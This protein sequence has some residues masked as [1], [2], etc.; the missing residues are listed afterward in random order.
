MSMPTI[1]QIVCRFLFNSDTPPELVDESLIRPELAEGDPVWVDALE[2]MSTGGGRF[3]DVARFNYIRRFLEGDDYK[4]LPPPNNGEYYTTAEL[5]SN[6]GI[7]DGLLSIPQYYND[8]FSADFAVRAYVFGSSAFKI[9][10]DARFYVVHNADGTTTRW[11]D[12]VRVEPVTDNFDYDSKDI[13]A[14]ITNYLTKD[15]IDPSGIGRTVPIKFDNCGSIPTQTLQQSD[16]LYLQVRNIAAQAAED[17]NIALIAGLPPYFAGLFVGVMFN[18]VANNI[19]TYESDG[20]FVIYDGKGPGNN[21]V[22]DA[23][24]LSSAITNGLK[25]TIV[26]GG[27]GDDVII[28]T[29]YD[30]ALIGGQGADHLEG[31]KGYDTYF[32][33]DQDTIM[34]S[35]GSGSVTLNGVKLDGE[36][37]QIGENEFRDDKGNIFVYD[38]ASKLLIVN[39]GLRIEN[40]TNGQ[41]GI[42]LKEEPDP[43]DSDPMKPIKDKCQQAAANSSPIILDL[44]GD[45][46]ETTSLSAKTHFDHAADGFAEQTGWVG[47][48]DGFLVRDLNGNGLIDSGRELFGSETLLANG[49]KA[50]NGFEALKELDSNSDGVIDANDAAFAELRIWKDA[51]GNGK[52]DE[53]E[54][55]TLAEAGVQ[56]I[57]LAYTQANQTDAQ[58]NAH[59]QIGSYTTTDGQIRA[60]TDVWFATDP[61]YSVATERGAVSRG[62]RRHCRPAQCQ[63][64]RQGARFAS[65]HGHGCLRR[66]QSLGAGFCPGRYDGGARGTGAPDHLPLGGG[67]R[68]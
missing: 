41:L 37:F 45:G 3:A 66:T 26:L 62:F 16:L 5:L 55:L 7:G 68:H 1:E 33:D 43:E 35:D 53:G 32:A 49:K 31:G 19:I 13:I 48:D 23:M 28:G 25:G 20:K 57:N 17:A 59:K 54:L 60:A 34:D 6:Y 2:F 46:V 67:T 56:S 21:G 38:E 44:D 15:K 58:G 8:I 11:I 63:G 51:N 10:D 24:A 52:T 42:T 14:T 4:T 36:A 30:D 64:L 40:F 22:I 50:A 12:N 29:H 61:T 39:G 9:N 27:G 47:K 65:G 18:L